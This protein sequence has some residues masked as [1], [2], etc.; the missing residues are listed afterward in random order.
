MSQGPPELLRSSICRI[1]KSRSSFKYLSKRIPRR[2]Q[3][4]R[5]FA[6]SRFDEE[7]EVNSRSN[8]PG[9]E[10][11]AARLPRWK[12]TPPRMTAPFRSKPPT[13]KPNDFP[14]NE[15]PERLDKVYVDLLGKKGDQVLTEE[16]KW[17]AVT[18]KS[19]DHGR[20]GYNDR[21]A[22]LGTVILF[23]CTRRLW[24]MCE[25]CRQTDC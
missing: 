23:V 12:A 19:F 8:Y 16:V 20:R 22:F 18:H 13:F 4:E 24:L 1:G 21:L 7:S 17:L 11:E 10:A 15:D 25:V 3:P 9:E 2:Q 14:V 5:T 6:S